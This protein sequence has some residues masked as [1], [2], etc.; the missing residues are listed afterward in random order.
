MAMVQQGFEILRTRRILEVVAITFIIYV[1]DALT[2]WFLV[3]G[4]GLTLGFSNT[5]VLLGA[6]SLSTLVPSGPA[7]LGTLQF[8][9]A[10]AVEF[11]GGARALGIAAATLAQLCLLLP[12]A[13]IAA[14]IIVHGSGTALYT[15]LRQPSDDGQAGQ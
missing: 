3:K 13:V 7:F 15:I 12:L 4:V 9:Y 1:P 6:A 8:A 14:A 5:L 11:A 10:L 2:L